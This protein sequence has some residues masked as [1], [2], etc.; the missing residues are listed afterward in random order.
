ME[1]AL[2]RLK[3]AGSP[4]W[5]A[6]FQEAGARH[7]QEMLDCCYRFRQWERQKML[8]ENP[9]AET[10][11]LHKETLSGLIKGVEWITKLTG[12]PDSFERSFHQKFKNLGEQ[13]R[14]SWDMFYNPPSGEQMSEA[15]EFLAATFPK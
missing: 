14:M 15:D 2:D 11:K 1:S 3:P 6:S 8:E 5:L 13:L 4:T 7:C 10:V 9:T 12:H